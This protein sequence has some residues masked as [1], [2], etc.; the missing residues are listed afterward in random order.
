MSFVCPLCDESNRII[1]DINEMEVD[2]HLIVFLS[3]VKQPNGKYQ[4][5]FHVHGPVEDKIL[6]R[7][8]V[9]SIC[10]EAGIEVEE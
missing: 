4:K 6:M 9:K 2:N 10:K 3:L 7:E 1:S 5:V 8:F